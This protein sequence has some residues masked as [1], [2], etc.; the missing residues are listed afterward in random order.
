MEWGVYEEREREREQQISRVIAGALE[1][2]GNGLGWKWPLGKKD[3]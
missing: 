2:F 1:E 3:T